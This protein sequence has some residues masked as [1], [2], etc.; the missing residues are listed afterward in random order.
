MN[1]IAVYRGIIDACCFIVGYLPKL[2]CD[3][4]LDNRVRDVLVSIVH[5]ADFLE[6]AEVDKVF[7]SGKPE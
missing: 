6:T 7:L 5:L 3:D 1:D 2:N 4:E